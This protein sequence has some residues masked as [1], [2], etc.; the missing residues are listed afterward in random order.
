MVGGVVCVW[1]VCVCR[2][3][4]C[5]VSVDVCVVRIIGVSRPKPTLTPNP[6]IPQAPPPPPQRQVRACWTCAIHPPSSCRRV[7]RIRGLFLPG[8]RC[9][10]VHQHAPPLP[11]RHT[12]SRQIHRRTLH[13]LCG[14][15]LYG[16]D[17]VCYRKVYSSCSVA[18][19][20]G[21][22]ADCVLWW[23]VGGGVY[24]GGCTG[25]WVGHQAGMCIDYYIDYIDYYEGVKGGVVGGKLCYA[26]LLVDGNEKEWK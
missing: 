11:V 14:S 9:F 10:C 6:C 16:C 4:G 7:S 5:V 26:N 12:S 25:G 1:L 3:C 19:C 2:W 8:C 13:A 24:A 18:Y 21:V 20:A 22:G 15:C 23:V 17:F